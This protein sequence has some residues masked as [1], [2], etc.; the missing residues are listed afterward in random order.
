MEEQGLGPSWCQSRAWGSTCQVIKCLVTGVTKGLVSNVRQSQESASQ[1]TR[2]KVIGTKEWRVQGHRGQFGR[3]V[4]DFLSCPSRHITFLFVCFNWESTACSAVCTSLSSPEHGCACWDY[5]ELKT[6]W[7]QLPAGTCQAQ[8]HC[9]VFMDTSVG[10]GSRSTQNCCGGEAKCLAE[11]IGETE[12]V[13]VG[14]QILPGWGSLAITP[15]LNIGHTHRP[16]GF[17]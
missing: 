9:C 2:V 16:L 1:L 11:C 10:L 12:T 7:R 15:V 13:S 8:A 4:K 5:W 3:W 6:R 14:A 17:N